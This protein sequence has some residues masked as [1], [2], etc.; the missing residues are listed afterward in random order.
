VGIYSFHLYLGHLFK[1]LENIFT[2]INN[3]GGFVPF[4]LYYPY[5]PCYYCTCF[6]H[7]KRNDYFLLFFACD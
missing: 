2:W 3:S 4:C 6:M 7:S 5:F 1:K